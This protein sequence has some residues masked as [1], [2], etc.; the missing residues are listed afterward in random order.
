LPAPCPVPATCPD[1]VGIP[2][3]HVAEIPGE[4][5][6]VEIPAVEFPGQATATSP[7][8]G[9][10]IQAE[11]LG[12]AFPEEAFLVRNVVEGGDFVRE[13][14]TVVMHKAACQQVV[15]AVRGGAIVEAGH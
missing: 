9:L 4:V 15:V 10:A 7:V 5:I 2:A 6:P 14:R 13:S 3:Y 8:Q 12:L 1:L 11:I